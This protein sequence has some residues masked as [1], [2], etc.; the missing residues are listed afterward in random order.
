MGPFDHPLVL[1]GL[2]AKEFCFWDGT[3]SANVQAVC[4]PAGANGDLSVPDSVGMI[5][6]GLVQQEELAFG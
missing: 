3:D 6:Y 1:G 4:V 2:S 5:A